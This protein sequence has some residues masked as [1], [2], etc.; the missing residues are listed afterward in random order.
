MNPDQGVALWSEMYER[1]V[2]DIFTTQDDVAQ[3]VADTVASKLGV[4]LPH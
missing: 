2:S 3:V 4:H 1:T